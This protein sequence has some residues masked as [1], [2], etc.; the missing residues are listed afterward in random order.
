MSSKDYFAT[1]ST[2]RSICYN[3]TCMKPKRT[4]FLDK[5]IFLK[6]LTDADTQESELLSGIFRDGLNGRASLTTSPLVIVE[7]IQ[8]LRLRHS[9]ARITPALKTI[10]DLVD[11]PE[12]DTCLRAL[13]IW[14]AEEIDYFDA[15][16]QVVKSDLGQS[17]I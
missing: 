15:Y 12:R 10:L 11:F 5:S 17:S 13:Y 6:Y 8:I 9:K 2:P 7:L 4:L 1:W 16:A 14:E 3:A